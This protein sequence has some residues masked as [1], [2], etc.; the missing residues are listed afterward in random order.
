MNRQEI[1]SWVLNN[2][3]NESGKRFRPG[4]NT[5]VWWMM[6]EMSKVVYTSL[7]HHYK[8]N[9][10]NVLAYLQDI[11]YFKCITCGKLL[12]R[13][14]MYCDAHCQNTGPYITP[15]KNA[16]SPEVKARR[17]KTCIEK[18]GC[19]SPFG[20][21][22]VQGKSK[23]TNKEKYGAESVFGKDSSVRLKVEETQTRLYGGVGFQS[24]EIL[25]KTHNTQIE[26]YGAVGLAAE[27]TKKKS[28]KTRKE[29][30]PCSNLTEEQC[31]ELITT[32][33]VQGTADF[34][35]A[36]Y[37]SVYNAIHRLGLEDLLKKCDS[38]YQLE[39]MTFVK[40][41]YSGTVIKDAAVLDNKEIDV[42]L[43]ELKLG[44][45]C[46]GIYY[47]SSKY[48]DPGY[49]AWKSS[50]ARDNGIR[51]IH[52][53]EDEW[54]D[55]KD[56]WK[57]KIKHLI[58]IRDSVIY[59]R[60]TICK[61]ITKK[62]SKPFLEKYHIQGVGKSNKVY[63]LFF[64]DELVSVMTFR[65]DKEDYIL[66]RFCSSCTVTGGFSKLLKFFINN[67]DVKKIYSFLDIASNGYHES[68]YDRTGFVI[69]K[70][71]RHDYKY[72]YKGKRV[73]K[74]NFRHKHLAKLLKNYDPNLSE[75]QNTLNNN[76]WQIYDSGKIRYVLN[77]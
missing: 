59:A 20:N 30:S 15:F 3:F 72:L 51:L 38:L 42:Y 37:S 65:K 68:V 74:F 35:G 32:N 28:Q 7:P 13:N 75:Y 11:D 62:D 9:I 53:F 76:I 1:R 22:E 33:G 23:K 25:Q 17:H 66:D 47:H 14:K 41:V 58:G 46:D 54:Y 18:Y 61:E 60:K 55:H 24:K 48:V 39:I 10:L 36:H 4:V 50:K 2:C 56:I 40:S 67:N 26:R 64:E 31:Y 52:I 6:T 71:L 29:N 43:P 16:Q 69:D 19:V 77:T 63:G 34:L 73:H 12:L 5:E 44:F 49:H 21:K 70:I 57:E 8:D 27:Q 45:E